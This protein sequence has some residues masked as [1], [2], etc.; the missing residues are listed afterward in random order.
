MDQSVLATEL[1]TYAAHKTEL[2]AQSRG[3]YVLIHGD[4]VVG[5]FETEGDAITE[6]IGSSA[7]CRF[8]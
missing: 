4:E 1:A 7:T 3:K 5:A 8:S 6:G 2:L